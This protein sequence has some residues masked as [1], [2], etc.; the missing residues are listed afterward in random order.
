[1]DWQSTVK[2]LD[3]LR[4][5]VQARRKLRIANGSSGNLN[6]EFLAAGANGSNATQDFNDL[7]ALR[8]GQQ[9]L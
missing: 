5:G 3:S 8:V 4:A 9:A 6:E 2:S 1:M 7:S